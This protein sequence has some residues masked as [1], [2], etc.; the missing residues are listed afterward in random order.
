MDFTN[1]FRLV[2]IAVGVFMVLGGISN[3]FSGSF[4]SIILGAYVVV[5]GLVI[6]GLEFLPHVP[7]YAYRYA[8]FL[9]SFLGRGV[10]YIFIG[11]ILLHDHVLRIIDG[12]L[13][14]FIGLAYVALEFIPS[15][16]P[17]ANMRESDQGWGAEQV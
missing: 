15:I 14:G 1:I 9:F 8:S 7:D 10:F 13:V 16:E 4:S 11:S 3:F 12:S 2:N 17:P 5:F 6:A